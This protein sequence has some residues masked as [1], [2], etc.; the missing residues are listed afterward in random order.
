MKYQKNTKKKATLNLSS[1]IFSRQPPPLTNYFP[2]HRNTAASPLGF[3]FLFS[4]TGQTAPKPPRIIV[5]FLLSFLPHR[6][7]LSQP[8]HPPAA[9]HQTS[10]S[11]NRSFVPCQQPHKTAPSPALP[12]QRQFVSINTSRC[13]LII[14]SVVPPSSLPATRIHQGR[15]GLTSFSATMS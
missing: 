2:S 3:D 7:P 12:S 1:P 5:F 10:L 11:L 13:S 14:L 6:Q 8:P 4:T 9:G 15:S